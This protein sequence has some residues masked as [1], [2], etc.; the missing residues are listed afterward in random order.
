MEKLVLICLVFYVNII[1]PQIDKKSI[2]DIANDFI[3]TL[4]PDLRK[5]T[6]FDLNSPERTKFYFVPIDR[7]G[8]SL[9]SLNNNQK[10]SALK[11]LRASLSKDGF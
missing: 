11:L 9:N 4:S 3:S 8:V 6:L 2:E 1:Y 10:K 7:K 5:K